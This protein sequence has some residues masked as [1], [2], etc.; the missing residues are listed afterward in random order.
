MVVR[1]LSEIIDWDALR[2]AVSGPTNDNYVMYIVHARNLLKR[3]RSHN[4]MAVIHY[5]VRIS[6]RWDKE[7]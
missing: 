1:R 6:R 3:T 5:V 7:K 4:Q 2:T